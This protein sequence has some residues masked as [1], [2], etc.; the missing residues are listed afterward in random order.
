[1]YFLNLT[2]F[3][4]LLAAIS[5]MAVMVVGICDTCQINNNVACVNETHYRM[6]SQNVAPNQIL[7]CGEGKVCTEYAAICLP[8]NAVTPS[9]PTDAANG[10]CET[11]NGNNLFVC[12]SRTTFQMCDG[13]T[14]SDQVTYCKDDKICSISS[15][16]FC[17]DKCEITGS[18]E[19]D[20]AAP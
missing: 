4:C 15:G 17:V 19:C 9:C 8:R 11:C 16:K 10:A 2:H 1:V 13:T 7:P 5:S 6:C 20:R 14:M 3:Q 18:V 12:T